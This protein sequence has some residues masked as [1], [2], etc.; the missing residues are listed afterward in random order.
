MRFSARRTFPTVLG[1]LLFSGY[2]M[3]S[4]LCY[5][6]YEGLTMEVSMGSSSLNQYKATLYVQT[7]E[8]VNQ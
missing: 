6:T 4:M 5:A 8:L 2:S 3:V 1:L 7:L